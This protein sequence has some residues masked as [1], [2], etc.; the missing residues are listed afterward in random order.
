MKNIKV[1]TNFYYKPTQG[2]ENWVKENSDWAVP[3]NGGGS[4]KGYFKNQIEDRKPELNWMLN[5]NSALMNVSEFPDI[6]SDAEAVGLQNYRRVFKKEDLECLKD[7]DGLVAR[8]IRL[9]FYGQPVQVKTQYGLMHV[10]EDFTVFE[11]A[12]EDI[13][14]ISY[15]SFLEWTM[16]YDLTAPCDTFVFKKDVFM[17]YL[18]DWRKFINT[19]MNRL[20]A[21]ELEKRDEY[22]R[23]AL[24]FLS[25]RFLSL[26]VFSQYVQGRMKFKSVDLEEHLDWKPVENRQYDAD[27]TLRSF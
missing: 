2:F 20:P 27:G 6:I 10:P 26:W 14:S 25:E 12:V 3:F 17:K 8:S 1:L 11:Y 21:E 23:R 19:V 4:Y 9:G 15:S 18:A 5:E 16:L 7:Y 22:Q 24:A 13:S